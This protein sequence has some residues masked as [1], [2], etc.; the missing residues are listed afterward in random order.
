M[1]NEYARQ[2]APQQPAG[3]P[4]QEA[5]PG[6]KA[7]TESLAVGFRFLKYVMIAL[8]AAYALSGVYWVNEGEVVIHSRFGR[9][10]GE[11]GAE[12]IE[13]GG[14]YFALPSPVDE[15]VVIPTTLQD[16]AVDTAFWFWETQEDE[17]KPLEKRRIAW[18]LQPGWDGSLLTADK[19]LVHGRWRVT[20]QVIHGRRDSQ[21]VPAARLFAVNVGSAD[22]AG[23]LVRTAAEQA[24]VRVVG[25]T[26]VDDFVRGR[27]DN[28]LV[29]KYVQ[30]VL[31]GLHTGI[32]ITAVSQR[33]YTVPLT[34]LRDFQAVNEAQSEKAL[35]I[36]EAERSRSMRLNM[37][38]GAG[39]QKL[40]EAIDAY[41]RAREK[42]G[43]GEIETAD[44]RIGRVLTS[45][46]VGGSV[47]EMIGSAKAY[48]TQAVEFVKGAAERFSRLAGEHEANPRILENRLLQDTLEQVLSGDVKKIYLPPRDDKTIYL[49]MDRAAMGD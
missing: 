36:E 42:G 17:D 38:A 41:E 9:I 31:D 12:V 4:D 7:L 19:N 3:L 24:I 20:Y 10:L 5:D 29:A 13:P 35:K 15:V 22:E 6:V 21:E 14:P 34:V 26:C 28:A 48:R 40:L 2:D 8:L 37:V 25:R 45:P 49:E 30:E 43:A 27:I 33:A 11:R 47:A 39:F 18:T 23:R 32:S 44:A 46:D 1:E 16:V